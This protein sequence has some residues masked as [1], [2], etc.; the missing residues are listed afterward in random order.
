MHNLY[1]YDH[2]L[3][4]MACFEYHKACPKV[5]QANFKFLVFICTDSAHLSGVNITNLANCLNERNP[6]HK[7]NGQFNYQLFGKQ[8][9]FFLV[10]VLPYILQSNNFNNSLP[11]SRGA[12][13]EKQYPCSKLRFCIE[14][15]VL[16]PKILMLLDTDSQT[17]CSYKNSQMVNK[18]FFI[19]LS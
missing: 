16:H 8:S 15:T 19:T 14:F 12:N 4:N 6:Y 13:L 10:F 1:C 3:C 17:T 9:L 2:L 18:N 5:I 11:L 7:K